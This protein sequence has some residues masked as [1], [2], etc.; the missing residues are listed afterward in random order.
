M[1]RDMDLVRRILSETADSERP[2]EANVF[3]DD[4]HDYNSVGYHIKIMREAGLIEAVIQRADGIPY[5]YCR[6]D[7]LTW[8][9]QE[10][11]ANVKSDSVWSKV[12]TTVAKRTG[13]ASFSVIT[14][15]AS[16]F[17]S[18]SLLGS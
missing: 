14:K 13:D 6:V 17:V 5:Y 8:D 16:D 12:K 4:R 11:L 18:Q 10:F 1:R 3:V 9:G 2:L 15:L 7:D